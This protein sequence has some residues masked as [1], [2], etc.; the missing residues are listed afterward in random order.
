MRFLSAFF[1]SSID[2][3]TST[4]TSSVSEKAMMLTMKKLFSPSRFK[5]SYFDSCFSQIFRKKTG[6]PRSS[7]ESPKNSSCPEAR[8]SK[9]Q[10][11]LSTKTRYVLETFARLK[12]PFRDTL[13]IANLTALICRPGFTSE[14]TPST[15]FPKSPSSPMLTQQLVSS[16]K[17]CFERIF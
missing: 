4:L 3:S 17:F 1:F 16:L 6:Y 14:R 2:S 8:S 10:P 12:F 5:F 11:V 15:R 7:S 9:L 13:D